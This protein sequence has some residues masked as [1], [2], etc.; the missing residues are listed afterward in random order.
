[1]AEVFSPC[2]KVNFSFGFTLAEVLITLGIIG[3]VAAITL[4]TLIQNSQRRELQVGL[5]KGYSTISQ[6]LDMYYAEN[7]VRLNQ[8]IVGRQKLKSILIKYIKNAKDCGVDNED[9]RCPELSEWP[10]TNYNNTNQAHFALFDDGRFV[11]RDGSLI[12]IENV[13]LGNSLY[14]SIDVNGAKKGPNRFGHDL[15]TFQIMQDGKLL[16]MGTEGT[17][18]VR[19]N[20]CSNTSTSNFNGV[21]CTAR[22]LYDKDYFKNLPK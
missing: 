9:P 10:Y 20:Y 7:G 12:L 5:K 16:P 6:A 13:L 21:T 11:L 17:D 14:I 22:A 18:Y 4:P 2:R 15:F 3:V 1:M 19:N 8:N